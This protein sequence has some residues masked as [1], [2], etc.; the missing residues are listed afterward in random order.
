MTTKLLIVAA[1]VAA[2][3]AAVVELVAPGTVVR[4]SYTHCPPAC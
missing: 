3:G 4:S 1:M 2:L